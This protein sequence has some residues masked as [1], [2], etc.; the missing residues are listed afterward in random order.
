M[1]IPESGETVIIIEQLYGVFQRP[2]MEVWL[3]IQVFFHTFVITHELVQK[4]FYSRVR[5]VLAKAMGNNQRKQ[6]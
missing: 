2:G 3:E 6:Q 1:E 4:L 5:P